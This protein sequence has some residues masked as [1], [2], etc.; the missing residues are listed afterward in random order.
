MNDSSRSFKEVARHLGLSSEDIVNKGEELLGTLGLDSL[1]LS[2]IRGLMAPKPTY[3]VL[4]GLTINQILEK[5]DI[6]YGKVNVSEPKRLNSFEFPLTPI[7]ESYYMGILQNKPCQIYTEIDIKEVD[8]YILKK[9]IN[10]VVKRHPM[11]RAKITDS[12]LQM[13][14]ED[15]TSDIYITD[16]ENFDSIRESCIEKLRSNPELYWDVQLSKVDAE[17]TRIHI[18]ID[19]IFIDAMSA[20]QLCKEISDEYNNMLVGETTGFYDEF[21]LNFIDYCESIKKRKTSRETM[22]FWESK[23]SELPNSPNLPITTEVSFNEMFF[24]RETFTLKTE[25]WEFLKD[26]SADEGISPNSLIIAIFSDVLKLYSENEDFTLAITKSNRPVD[27]KN[28]FAGVVGNF[29]DVTLCPIIDRYGQNVVSKAKEIN[30]FL[31]ISMEHDDISGIDIIKMLKDYY[32]DQHINFPV[33]FTSFLGIFESGIQLNGKEFIL[34]YQRTQTPQI[35]LDCQIYE[36]NNGLVVNWDYDN[37]IYSMDLIRSMMN[38][39]EN[40]M[41]KLTSNQSSKAEIPIKSIDLIERIN[42]TSDDFGDTEFNALHDL[43]EGNERKYF[44]KTAIIDREYTL[45][46]GEMIK[47]SRMLAGKLQKKGVKPGSHVPIILKKGWEQVVAALAVLMSGGIFV[48][49][50]HKDPE[51]RLNETVKSLNSEL[52]ISNEMSISLNSVLRH[53]GDIEFLDITYDRINS[54]EHYSYNPIKVADNQLAYII[55]TSGS[56][57]KPKGVEISHNSAINTCL[58]INKKFSI[59]DDSIAFG[60]SAFNFDLSIWDIFGVLG[61]GGTLVICRDDKVRDPDYWWDQIQNHNINIWNSVPTTF[62]MLL[63][64]YSEDKKN[65]LELSLLSGDAIRFSL[66]EKAQEIFPELKIVGLGGATEA[67]IWSNYHVYSSKSK[68]LGSKLLP[69]GKPLANQQIY[70]LDKNLKYR[71]QNVVGDIYIGGKGLAKGYFNNKKLTQKSFINSDRFG[72]LYKTGDLGRYLSNGE[73]EILGRRDMQMKIGGHRIELGEIE[74][75]V[76]NMENIIKVNVIAINTDTRYLVGFVVVNRHTGNEEIEIKEYLANYVPAYMIP[77]KWIIIDDMPS[78]LNGKVDVNKLK[79]IAQYKMFEFDNQKYTDTSTNNN[80]ILEKVSEL[81]EISPQK[82]N[83]SKSL[84]EQGLTSL[85]A[86]KLV[87]ILSDMWNTKL[88]YSLLFNNPSIEKLMEYYKGK[89]GVEMQF[90]DDGDSASDDSIAV[91]SSSCRLPGGVNSTDELWDMLLERK[92]CITKVPPSRFDIDTI[93]NTNRD[94]VNSSYTNKGAFIDNVEYFDYD[95]FSIPLAE[96]KAMD[97]QQRILLEVLYEAC[98]KGGYGKDELNGSDTGVFIGQMNYDWMTDFSFNKE[99]AGTGVSP[100]IT[101]NRISY[102]LNLV[103]PSMTIDTACSSSLVAV[104]NAVSSLLSN[105]CSMAIAGGVNLILS[106][107]P[108]ITTCK[109]GMLSIDGRCATFDSKANGIARGEGVGV[110]VLKR[111]ADAKRDGDNIISVIKGTAVNQDGKSASLTI[112]NGYAQENVINKALNRANIH[113]NDIDYIECHGTGTPLGDPIEVEAIKNTLGKNRN[114][115]LVL[116]SIK[117]NIGHLEGAAGIVGLI[118][119][120]EVLKHKIAPGNVH[121]NELNPKISFDDFNAVISSNNINIGLQKD[122][123]LASVSSFGYG[124]TNAHVI[125]ESWNNE[126]K[127]IS[128]ALP[129]VEKQIFNSKPLPWNKQDVKSEIQ[130][131]IIKE[132]VYEIN[133]ELMN[134]SKVGFDMNETSYLV[135]SEGLID[136]LPSNWKQVS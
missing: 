21:R 76:Q 122:S 100:S 11:L 26:I 117:T 130:K 127:S 5:I 133:W 53:N 124:G 30:D 23:V 68:R 64:A 112:P 102:I 28:N 82:I 55:F 63:T 92:D 91:I 9:S 98:Y 85:H 135:I 2:R 78:T 15:S 29:T 7:Q 89:S 51:K 24:D 109:A 70:V 62:E 25:C 47:L 43:I 129:D 22:L 49:L 97:P 33:V 123:I 101:S 66:V 54:F 50:N 18:I 113:G 104:D 72:R 120:I 128:K 4:S 12:G 105:S 75:C 39:M 115:P 44:T 71:P 59:G 131:N 110:V 118:K 58:D 94:L 38:E 93:Y 126:N 119:T 27:S 37:K 67:S 81:L 56:T 10:R 17:T 74:K 95:F 107:E 111:L 103:G 136:N 14:R 34:N 32:K 80:L 61:A 57:G 90:K 36:N 19:M 125:L 60:I 73:I 77:Q 20:M 13:V 41:I 116:G 108:Y 52:V 65:Q 31:R 106:K 1:T 99:Y 40:L 42:D 8:V 46:Y 96:A 83:M 35:T 88:P 121:F 79:E 114:Y 86:V 16:N 87:N 69:Y 134:S 45:S 48:P 132:H 3:Q 84:F 6:S